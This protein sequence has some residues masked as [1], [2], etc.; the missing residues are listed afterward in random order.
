MQHPICIL[1]P[2]PLPDPFVFCLNV[3]IEGKGERLIA[4]TGVADQGLAES[5]FTPPAACHKIELCIEKSGRYPAQQLKMG[6]CKTQYKN[7]KIL[8]WESPRTPQMPRCH[9]CIFVAVRTVLASLDV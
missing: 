9:V 2:S 3:F 7:F 4:V 6:L 5:P 1:L 8:D